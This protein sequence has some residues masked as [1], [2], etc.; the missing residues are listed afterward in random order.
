M[1]RE[2]NQSKYS[3]LNFSSLRYGTRFLSGYLLITSIILI[4]GV[5]YLLDIIPDV[6]GIILVLSDMIFEVLTYL[7]FHVLKYSVINLPSQNLI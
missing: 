6:Y 2:Y 3:S 4:D 1:T 7:L 5:I